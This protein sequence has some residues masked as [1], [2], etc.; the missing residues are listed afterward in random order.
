MSKLVKMKNWMMEKCARKGNSPVNLLT[1]MTFFVAAFSM[2]SLPVLAQSVDSNLQFFNGALQ[3]Q[4]T[5]PKSL[6]SGKNANNIFTVQVA[7]AEGTAYPAITK[8]W[9]RANVEMT[10]MDMG[11]TQVTRVED[12]L[13]ANK[14]LQGKI[15]LNPSFMMTGPWRL[16]ITIT[17]SGDDGQPMT[18]TQSVSFDVN[19]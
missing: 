4:V 2:M 9:I 3:V 11:V 16:N 19:K 14:Q 18:D 15:S 13:D 10:N 17:V 1:W 6:V 5:G 8:E 7:D 12:V